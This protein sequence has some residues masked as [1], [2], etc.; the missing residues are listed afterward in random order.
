[1]L[2]KESVTTE[3]NIWIISTYFFRVGKEKHIHYK[4]VP[5]NAIPTCWAIHGIHIETEH[6]LKCK[7]RVRCWG[8]NT[9]I[10]SSLSI[11]FIN[12]N[13]CLHKSNHNNCKV[14]RAHIIVGNCTTFLRV[15]CYGVLNKLCIGCNVLPGNF[16]RLLLWQS[17]PSLWKMSCT[18]LILH[19]NHM[20][21]TEIQ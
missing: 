15:S 5:R 19:S 6:N 16:P 14:R 1:M 8:T 7:S 17:K 21:Q 13:Q 3:M 2:Q 12:F 11:S 20:N 4:L 10:E 9:D 18:H